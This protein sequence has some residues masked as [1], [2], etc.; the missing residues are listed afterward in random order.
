MKVYALVIVC[1][2]SGACTI[3]EMEGCET[4]DVVASI[5]RHSARYGVPGYIYIDNGTQLKAL[6]HSSLSLRDVYAQIQDSLGI[7]IVTSTA[8][9]HSDRGW[10][11]CKI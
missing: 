1:L 2:L 4:Q 11:E 3:L 9:A 5:E 7:K 8:K 6:K 10:V